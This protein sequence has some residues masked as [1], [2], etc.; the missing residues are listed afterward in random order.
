M[1]WRENMLKNIIS[2]KKNLHS[3]EICYNFAIAFEKRRLLREAETK[4][5][6]QENID[7]M[8]PRQ[9]SVKVV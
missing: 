8:L 4:G 3:G 1:V 5:K 7:I 6:T 2:W 9:S